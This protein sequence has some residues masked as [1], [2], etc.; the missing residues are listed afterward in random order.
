MPKDTKKGSKKKTVTKATKKPKTKGKVAKKRVTKKPT[1]RQKRAAKLLVENGGKSV[2][3]AMRDAG[4]SEQTAKSPH[5]LTKS[6]AWP[7]LMEEF[8]PQEKVAAA[9]A[10][11]LEAEDTVF[12]P[13]GK[14][15]LERKRPDFRARKAGIDMAHK[16]RGNYAPE[17]I[18]LSRRKFQDMSDKE[19]AENITAMKK[20]LLKK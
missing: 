5:K 13:R 16:L 7:A 19:L 9:H 18:E 15:I 17:Q 20:Q 8:L 10:E 14:K 11:L 4:Y 2:S 1:A 6:K 12:I 3:K